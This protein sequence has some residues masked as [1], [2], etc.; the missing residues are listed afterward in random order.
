MDMHWTPPAAKSE[1]ER[2]IRVSKLLTLEISSA[3]HPRTKIVV[4]NLSPH[5]MGVRSDLAVL[6]CEHVTLYL[7]NGT[8]VGGIVRW[9]RKGTFGLS[10]DDRIEPDMLQPKTIGSGHITPSDEQIGFHRLQHTGTT[11]RSGFHRS[12]RD[13]VLHNRNGG[14][15]GASHWIND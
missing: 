5:G 8:E 2:E 6:P 11:V 13:E 9:V 3:R 15:A 4:R 7:P 1:D 10:L 14:Q 12:P